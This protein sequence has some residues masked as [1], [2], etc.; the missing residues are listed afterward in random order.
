MMSRVSG[1]LPPGSDALILAHLAA[2]GQVRAA[3][4]LDPAERK[5]PGKNQIDIENNIC[6]AISIWDHFHLNLL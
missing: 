3:Y 2:S 5:Y 1:I 4:F 6:T